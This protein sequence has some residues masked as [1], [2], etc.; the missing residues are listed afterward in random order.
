GPLGVEVDRVGGGVVEGRAF[1]ERD[2]HVAGD[3]DVVAGVGGIQPLDV[4]VGH[5]DVIVGVALGVVGVRRGPAD[6]HHRGV[7]RV[8]APEA[9]AGGSVPEHRHVAAGRAR[10]DGAGSS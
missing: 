6:I 3:R 8:V 2:V 9:R 10:A 1:V 4:V 7:G 5:V